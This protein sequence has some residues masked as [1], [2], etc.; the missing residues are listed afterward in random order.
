MLFSLCLSPFFVVQVHFT[1]VI[2]IQHPLLS[3]NPLQDTQVTKYVFSAA[4]IL[5][6][7]VSYG[8][9]VAWIETSC[10]SLFHSLI[11][12]LYLVLLQVFLYWISIQLLPL[13]TVH[14]LAS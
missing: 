9:P 8:H 12:C 11:H 1:Y 5:V 4:S 7:A 2:V 14:Y 10:P 3:Q 6:Q 13:H